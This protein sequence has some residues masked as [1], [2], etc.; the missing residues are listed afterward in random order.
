[1]A[2]CPRRTGCDWLWIWGNENDTGE[3][4]RVNDFQMCMNMQSSYMWESLEHLADFYALPRCQFV[5]G[6]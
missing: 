4:I 2:W 5:S 3:V 1:M 6:I